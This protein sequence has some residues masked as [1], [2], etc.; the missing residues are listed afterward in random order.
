MEDAAIDIKNR[1]FSIT[2]EVENPDGKAEGMLATM[3]G[4]T[5]GFGLMILKGKP[6]F[7][8]N[9]LGLEQYNIAS[10]EPLPKG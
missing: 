5:G 9:F 4:E 7:H 10:S 1:S 3:G 6:T 2:V 8:Y